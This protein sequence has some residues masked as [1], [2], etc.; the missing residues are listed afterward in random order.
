VFFTV[1]IS[2][3]SS[4]SRILKPSKLD[5]F[6]PY[7][8]PFEGPIATMPSLGNGVFR[9]QA[10]V[11]SVAGLMVRQAKVWW[12]H[13]EIWKFETTTWRILQIWHQN[14]LGQLCRWHNSF[15]LGWKKGSFSGCF[16]CRICP[17]RRLYL[18]RSEVK[19]Y[20]LGLLAKTHGVARRVLGTGSWDS[21]FHWGLSASPT[22]LCWPL[23]FYHIIKLYVLICT[24]NSF[25]YRIQTASSRTKW[26]I[27]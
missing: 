2:L 6:N 5:P 7:G 18:L 10:S 20:W 25:V 19:W 23:H 26:L 13:M 15:V 16:T 9:A 1:E 8:R 24:L 12:V 3:K 14:I 4:T 27:L 21:N 22:G 17:P 11:G